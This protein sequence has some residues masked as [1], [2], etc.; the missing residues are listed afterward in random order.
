MK[1]NRCN[2]VGYRFGRE[3][4]TGEPCDKCNGKGEVDWIENVLGS[5]FKNYDYWYPPDSYSL[6]KEERRK[7]K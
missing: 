4:F 6:K 1:C 7:K 5:T 2:G 3:D